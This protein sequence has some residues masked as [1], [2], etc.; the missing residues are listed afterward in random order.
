MSNSP[1]R[2]DRALIDVAALE[3]EA[4]AFVRS[5][6]LPAMVHFLGEL[7]A[8]KTTFVRGML[9]ALGHAGRVKSPTY[10]LIESYQLSV[11]PV[12]HL[13]LYRLSDPE[14]LYYL[15]FEDLLSDAALILVEWPERGA[16]LLP[17]ADVT[18]ELGYL[19]EGR[20]VAY[21]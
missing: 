3:Q 8:G 15:G 1:G 20:Q 17:A 5:L 11:G 21:R 4:A 9:N 13:D 19:A 18:I 14:E 7:G 10:T 12:H 2:P 6:P 16:P